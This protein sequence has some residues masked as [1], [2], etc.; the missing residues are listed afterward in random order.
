MVQNGQKQTDVSSKRVFEHETHN[1]SHPQLVH[2]LFS[3]YTIEREIGHGAQGRIFQGKRLSDNLTVA[4]KQLN[5]SS[6]KTWKEYELFHREAALLE[7]VHIS[8]VAKFYEAIE[9]LDDDPP[10][11]Y[12]VQEY[13]EGASLQKM[14][15]DG[16]R[17]KVDDV[18]DILIQTLRILAKLH[19][20]EPP[21]IH[22]D[23]KPSNLMITS[24]RNGKFKVT[25]IDFGAVANPQIQGGGSTV[26]GTFGYM[27]PEQLTGKP[28]PASDIYALAALAVQLFCGKSPADLPQKDFRLIFEPELQ[29]QPHELVVL[30]GQ[31]LDPKIEQRLADIPE[32]IQRLQNIQE[33]KKLAI[34]AIN[35]Q[36]LVSYPAEFEDKLS[37]VRAI[38]QN[39]NIELWKQL[40]DSVPRL[41]PYRYRNI[42][43]VCS[44]QTDY[45]YGKM[46]K[47]HETILKFTR[48][49]TVL[50]A[51]SMFLTIALDFYQIIPDGYSNVIWIFLWVGLF[52]AIIVGNVMNEIKKPQ[53]LFS[54]ITTEDTKEPN[55][56]GVTLDTLSL[57]MQ[58]LLQNGR[59]TIARIHKI[60]YIP[61]DNVKIT[62]M[63]HRHLEKKRVYY[64]ANKPLFKI[65]YS[66]NPPDDKREDNIIHSFITQADPENHY[67]VGDPLPILYTIEDNYFNDLVTSMPFPLSELDLTELMAGKIVD[68]SRGLLDISLRDTSQA[69][70]EHNIDI[71]HLLQFPEYNSENDLLGEIGRI[72]HAKNISQL[73][74]ALFVVSVTRKES[75][76]AIPYL[77]TVLME[78]RVYPCHATCIISLG[79]MAFPPSDRQERCF[80]ALDV[81]KEYMNKKPRCITNA[82]IDAFA[83]V[84]DAAT[85]GNFK[86]DLTGDFYALLVDMV[87]DQNTPKHVRRHLVEMIY[88]TCPLYVKEK[89]RE[90]I[91][92]LYQ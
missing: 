6:I 47:C 37:K 52:L 60:E 90:I 76:Q 66:F 86:D 88:S 91:A 30:L 63:R 65:L 54:E 59:K 24:D 83:M 73:N 10:C 28:A 21:I 87:A 11:S 68:R 70:E 72:V 35:T 38:G 40:P 31:M 19:Q 27:P 2:P 44:T 69:L 89:D 51:V 29:N 45:T 46:D 75:L 82:T 23:I 3:K 71:S 7:S 78:P 41:I 12:I 53:L 58:S 64:L 32:I 84:I 85:N 57:Q 43:D 18:Y 55:R 80:E 1:E 42:F 33:G 92:T 15:R 67:Q 49:F 8:G 16:H 34:K 48:F 36:Q 4:I 13:V 25:L 20:N 22:R 62:G 5:I 17:F 50:F 56:F 14:I 79:L 74:D 81:I 26:A 61:Q 9:C 77:K 39:G